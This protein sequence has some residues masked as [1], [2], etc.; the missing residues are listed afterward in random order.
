MYL[1]LDRA[2]GLERRL[3]EDWIGSGV[4]AAKG[5]GVGWGW[6]GV[7]VTGVGYRA[8]W[9]EGVATQMWEDQAVTRM[10]SLAAEYLKL[11]VRHV[12]CEPCLFVASR[13]RSSAQ[14]GS[15]G[16][17][18]SLPRRTAG[19]AGGRAAAR[20]E[21]GAPPGAG[22]GSGPGGGG[23]SPW[24]APATLL[25]GHLCVWSDAG[26][27]G[28]PGP[29][30]SAGRRPPA[31]GHRRRCRRLVARLPILARRSL[32]VRGPRLVRAVV[33]L[34]QPRARARTRP[35]GCR[36]DGPPQTALDRRGQCR[37]VATPPPGHS[38][39]PLHA[40]GR[41][42]VGVARWVVLRTQRR[43][44]AFAAT[45]RG[46]ADGR[47]KQQRKENSIPKNFFERSLVY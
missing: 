41:G 32:R 21:T 13:R 17:G 19:V 11:S 20:S 8:Y 7:G 37:P 38:G 18:P 3:E 33:G 27:P 5:R 9:D 16:A 34:N 14:E 47:A 29:E 30:S 46:D 6:G 23:E 25:G 10:D 44:A 4:A 40:G 24:S 42:S 15:G 12:V 43:G 1:R 36:V 39:G 26:G 45:S 31:G 22:P 2:V 28:S 35:A